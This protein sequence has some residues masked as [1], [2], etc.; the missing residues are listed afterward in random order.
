MHPDRQAE[1]S[2]SSTHS[3]DSLADVDSLVTKFNTSSTATTPEAFA[4]KQKQQQVE[5]KR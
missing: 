5:A 3:H 2:S 1:A 4:D